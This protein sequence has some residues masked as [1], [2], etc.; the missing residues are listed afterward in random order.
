MALN[1]FPLALYLALLRGSSLWLITGL[2]LIRC[3]SPIFFSQR[4]ISIV[5]TGG[6]KVIESCPDYFKNQR[7]AIPSIGLGIPF[8]M[9]MYVFFIW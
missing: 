9:A 5:P 4:G 7:N 3:L 1:D 8:V 6:N 2:R